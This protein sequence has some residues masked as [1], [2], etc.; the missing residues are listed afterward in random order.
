MILV[1]LAEA[2]LVLIVTTLAWRLRRWCPWVFLLFPLLGA[3]L[4]ALGHGIIFFSD[5]SGDIGGFIGFGLVAALFFGL[6][7]GFFAGCVALIWWLV[8]RKWSDR[9]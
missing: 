4:L 7:V 5:G 6:P 2:I 1:V 3:T 8:A 9:K